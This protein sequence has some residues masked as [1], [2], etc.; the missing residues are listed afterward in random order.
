[1]SLISEVS[2]A[3]EAEAHVLLFGD[4]PYKLVPDASPGHH[5][6]L[7]LECSGSRCC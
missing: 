6:H 3:T 4:T 7:P 5:L 2:E 1:M